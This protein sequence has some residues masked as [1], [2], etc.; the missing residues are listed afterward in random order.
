MP[1]RKEKMKVELPPIDW[2]KAVI[3]ERK[4]QIGWNYDELADGIGCT[5]TYLR[6]LISTKHT[7]DWN[8]RIK[9]RVLKKLGIESKTLLTG[10]GDGIT[11]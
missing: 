5:G 7:D 3:L 1:R 2:T 8:P 9:N 10:L 11:F 4:I 6:R